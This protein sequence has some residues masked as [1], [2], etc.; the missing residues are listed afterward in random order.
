ML[1]IEVFTPEWS[2]QILRSEHSR[3]RSALSLGVGVK[4]SYAKH[5][6]VALRSGSDYSSRPAGQEVLAQA[7]CAYSVIIRLEKITLKWFLIY[8]SE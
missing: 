1:N 8:F 5:S 4:D 6:R 2:K 7:S 3:A